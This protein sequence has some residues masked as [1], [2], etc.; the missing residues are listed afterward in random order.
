MDYFVQPF[1]EELNFPLAR[2]CSH[3]KTGVV[4]NGRE[5]HHKDLEL[6]KKRGLPGTP[7]KAYNVDIDGRLTEEITGIELKGLGRLAPTYAP[8][9]HLIT[10]LVRD[11][12][13]CQLHAL[14][15]RRLFFVQALTVCCFI[16]RLEQTGRGPGMWVPENQRGS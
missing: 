3:G 12:N 16:F 1:I 15:Q 14:L 5:L 2:H 10:R 11:R 6:L 9:N 13:C 8:L 7:G 4:V